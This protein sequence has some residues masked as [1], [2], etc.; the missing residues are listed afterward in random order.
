MDNCTTYMPTNKTKKQSQRNGPPTRP[1]HHVLG[2]ADTSQPTAT[3]ADRHDFLLPQREPLTC[4]ATSAP[5]HLIHAYLTVLTQDR[6]SPPLLPREPH[7]L[8]H[9]ASGAM[10]NRNCTSQPTD[11][12]T[13][14]I[15]VPT[16]SRT[17]P[18]LMRCCE[19]PRHVLN[20]V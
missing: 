18:S 20:A 5:V 13:T 1:R 8:W 19:K 17:A 6:Y 15:S 7:H 3:R 4:A 2:R 10:P 14:R 9:S 11:A 12:A 16:T